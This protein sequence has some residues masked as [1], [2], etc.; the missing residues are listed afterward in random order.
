MRSRILQYLYTQSLKSRT[1]AEYWNYID[2]ARV[3]RCAQ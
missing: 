2:A 1:L 3:V